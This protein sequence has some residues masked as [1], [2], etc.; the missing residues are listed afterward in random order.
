MSLL[1]DKH[2][3]RAAIFDAAEC[4][5]ALVAILFVFCFIAWM[6]G[7]APLVDL[8]LLLAGVF[9]GS[10]IVA[11]LRQGSRKSSQQR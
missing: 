3:F 9:A 8:L 2:R 6:A 5:S 1:A 7:I 4:A 11:V 10:F